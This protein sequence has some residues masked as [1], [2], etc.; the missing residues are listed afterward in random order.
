[1]TIGECSSEILGNNRFLIITE[2]QNNDYDHQ[3]AEAD[4]NEAFVRF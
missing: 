3:G 1:M 2:Q 4:I